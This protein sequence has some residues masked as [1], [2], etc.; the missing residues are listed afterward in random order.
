MC[1]GNPT[2]YIIIW[3]TRMVLEEKTITMKRTLIILALFLALFFFAHKSLERKEQKEVK[4]E[5]AKK[6]HKKLEEEA[7]ERPAISK[8]ADA[9]SV[10]GFSLRHGKN[11]ILEDVS[12]EVK[13]GELVC[14]LGP[15]GTG[16]STV[17]ESLV[18]RKTPD[19]GTIKILGEDIRKNKKIMDYVG[20]V[21]QGAEIYMNQP[22]EQNL[23]TSATKWGVKDAKKKAEKV[24]LD[25]NLTQRANIE[26]KKLSGGQQK[27]LSL[28]M[29]LIRD[30]ELLILDEP[31][32]GLD[33]N[34]RNN[35][36]TIISQIV[37]QRHKTAL[38][39]THFMDEAEY[40]DRIALI[41]RGHIIHM[42][43]PDALKEIAKTKENLNPT[44]DDAF[45]KLIERHDS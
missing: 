22:A 7:I 27:L 10:S 26:A 38:F 37:A 43:T 4:E 9:I 11:V 33:P 19:K 18:G 42:D 1:V 25:I 32:T 13:R 23:L 30:P 24:L 17:I 8:T 16:K 31:T 36:I 34:T 21:P 15:S 41:Y 6:M 45:I 14:L 2:G 28:G 29:E 3:F 40:C 20:F 5:E 39:T 12:F 44:L 35:I